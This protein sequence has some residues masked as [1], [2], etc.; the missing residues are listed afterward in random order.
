MW[1]SDPGSSRGLGILPS[2][3]LRSSAIPEAIIVISAQE[4]MHQQEDI[5]SQS[6]V[7]LWD[8]GAQLDQFTEWIPAFAGMTERREYGGRGTGMTEACEYDGKV[9]V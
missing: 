7:S 9:R 4:D 3:G 8:L 6:K 2:Q 1:R 5:G